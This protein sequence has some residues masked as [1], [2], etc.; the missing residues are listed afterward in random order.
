M[1][2]VYI[3]TIGILHNPINVL[4]DVGRIDNQEEI[5]FSHLVNQQ[6]IYG[7]TIG[8][9]HHAIVNLPDRSIGNIIREDMIDEFLRIIASYKYL[10]HVRNIEHTTMLAN[11]IVLI[12]DRGILDRHD[13]P[14]KWRHQCA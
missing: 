2:D 14:A 5:V 6:I 11:S 13:K 10:T 3:I 8:I 12:D 7:S 1:V 4:I 9:K